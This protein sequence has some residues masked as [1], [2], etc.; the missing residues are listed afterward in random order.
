MI[1][2]MPSDML[3]T[4][5]TYIEE[6]ALAREELQW[7]PEYHMAA[8]VGWVNDPN[9][10]CYYK[11]NYHLFYQHHPYAP[12]WGPMHWGHK[13]S[14]DLIHWQ[15]AKI[16]LA[17]DE[18]YDANGC[19]SGCG[20]VKDDKMYLMYTGH[21]DLPND[22]RIETQF[23]AASEDGFNFTKCSKDPVLFA[24]EDENI[25]YNGHFRDPKV[26]EHEGK[27]YVVI[28]A[29]T[30][31]ETGHVVLY[32]SDDLMHWQYK[33]I[34]AQAKGNEGFMWEC[35]NFAEIDGR[36]ALIFSPQGVKPEGYKFQNVH[37]SVYMLGSMDYKTGVF[38]RG[39]IHQLDYGSDFYAPQIMQN[40]DGRC[41]MIGWLDMWDTEM[42]EAQEKW[43]G[44]MT[45]PREL[46]IKDGAVISQPVA[47]MVNLRSNE[48]SYVNVTVDEEA[49]LDGIKGVSGELVAD[50]DM[51][52]AKTFKL[53]LRAGSKEETVLS[54][55]KDEAMFAVDRT[56]S[57]QGPQDVRK[58][59]AALQDNKLKLRIFLDKSSIEVFVNDGELVMSH[60]IYPAKESDGIR[61]SAAGGTAVLEK[62]AFYQLHK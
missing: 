41:L 49:A 26:W 52:N 38:T 25:V 53:A 12:K 19:F 36:E 43:A 28:G 56:K 1:M 62:V 20:L 59:P 11:G 23:L 22:G 21:V 27:F 8:P 42:P 54:Y 48:V 33:S 3:V 57:G 5:Q 47:E 13:Y 18:K 37:Q 39:D 15:D 55:N 17:P 58:A 46:H 32:E 14:S 10:F 35:P 34:M 31:Q 9:G 29:Q 45:I 61:F 30:P 16:A 50:V 24:P 44:M 40:A 7:Y 60:R 4:A 51:S 2:D 6:N